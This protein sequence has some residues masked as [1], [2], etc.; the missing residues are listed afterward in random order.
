MLDIFAGNNAFDCSNFSVQ[1]NSLGVEKWVANLF[2]WDVAV[3]TH[4]LAITMISKLS[5]KLIMNLHV[6][7]D[8]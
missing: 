1:I 5:N 6:T 4:I 2:S 7:T 3:S 8:T